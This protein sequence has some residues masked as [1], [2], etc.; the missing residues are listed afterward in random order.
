MKLSS[1]FSL[2]LAPILLVTVAYGQPSKPVKDYINVKGPIRFDNISYSLSWSSHPSA[3]LYK[4]EYIVK[5]GQ[6]DKYKTMI[7]MD[8]ITGNTRIEDVVSGKVLELK[9]IK[10]GNPM[11]NYE[12][13]EKNGETMIDF[14][15]SANSPDGKT[16]NIVE[17]NVYRYKKVT[18]KSGQKAVLLFGVSKRGYGNDITSFLTNL[19]STKSELL[20]KVGRYN[21]PEIIWP[22]Q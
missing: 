18:N 4:Q 12:L 13:L 8:V 16:I 9:N 7:L 19:K 22:A 17:H 10:A 14:L 15:L 11:V 21:I 20:N 5:G 2:L 3:Q 6:S 1:F